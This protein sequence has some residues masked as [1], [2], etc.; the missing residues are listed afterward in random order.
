MA[1]KQ[2]RATAYHEAG[3]VVIGRV[4]TVACGRATIRPDYVKRV[5]GHA[6]TKDPYSC[7]HEW[8]KRG[9]VRGPD[10][11]LHARIMAFMAGAE[12]EKLLLNI[13][14]RGDRDDR[15][16]I[17]LMAG[18]LRPDTKLPPDSKFKWSHLEPR[19][20]AMSVCWSFAIVC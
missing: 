14:A 18:L 10:A 13:E 8:E 20:R 19:L 7:L 2:L 5:G 3:H 17:D 4:L 9:C 11:H 15:I 6:I 1:T 12:V 16:Q